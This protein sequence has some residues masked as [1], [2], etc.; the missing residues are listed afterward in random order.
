MFVFHRRNGRW[1]R[2]DD[3]RHPMPISSLQFNLSGDR[4]GTL[5]L[6]RSHALS[7][8]TIAGISIAS[9]RFAPVIASLARIDIS[10][11]DCGDLL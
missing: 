5:S 11:L 1:W 7:W 8:L 9:L 4:S 10:F 2:V 3:H 6:T